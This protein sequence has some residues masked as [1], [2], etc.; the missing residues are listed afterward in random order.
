MHFLLPNVQCSLLLLDAASAQHV[1]D[2]LD[3]VGFEVVGIHFVSLVLSPGV[4]HFGLELVTVN[5]DRDIV[6]LDSGLQG[7]ESLDVP[8]VQSLA[9]SVLAEFEQHVGE[10]TELMMTISVK[11][12]VF[13][14]LRVSILCP[15][16]L[17]ELNILE[18]D[19][20]DEK[21]GLPVV[22]AVHTLSVSCDVS[23]AVIIFYSQ[24]LQIPQ[25]ITFLHL[26]S[27]D[28]RPEIFRFV[29]DLQFFSSKQFQL[30][31]DKID[32]LLSH[33]LLP[34]DF[35]QIHYLGS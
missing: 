34:V 21:L 25:Q 10:S 15:C 22:L 8:L 31:A 20:G 33:H 23:D 6:I 35:V 3:S 5:D 7:S 13:N 26:Q 12:S 30:I 14:H 29:V 11:S 24:I 17:E 1:P 4:K 28:V 32:F 2:P 9:L 18:D 16:L 19:L 27:A